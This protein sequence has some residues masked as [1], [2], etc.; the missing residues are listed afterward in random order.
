[1]ILNDLDFADFLFVARFQDPKAKVL[2]GS[3]VDPVL[4]CQPIPLYFIS[5]FFERPPLKLSHTMQVVKLVGEVCRFHGEDDH[6][7]ICCSKGHA[8][9]YV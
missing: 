1:M 8:C 7:C 6:V 4:D 2:P 9:H 5:R 3:I